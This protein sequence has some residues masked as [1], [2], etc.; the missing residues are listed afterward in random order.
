[1]LK[2]NMMAAMHAKSLEQNDLPSPGIALIQLLLAARIM[3][4]E[5]RFMLGYTK[6]FNR[7]E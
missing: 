1:M 2:A 4:V 3:L 6:A 5:F 7:Q